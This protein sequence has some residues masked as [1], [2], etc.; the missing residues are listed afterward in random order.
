ME[1]YPKAA[2]YKAEGKSVATRQNDSYVPLSFTGGTK[3]WILGASS[4]CPVCESVAK[5]FNHGHNF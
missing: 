4:F 3:S 5:N 2:S 1:I